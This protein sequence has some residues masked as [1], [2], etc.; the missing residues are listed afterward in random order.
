MCHIGVPEN[1]SNEKFDT[2]KSANV[3]KLPNLKYVK[4]KDVC[5]NFGS[6]IK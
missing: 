1:L 3:E 6:K 2:I 5:I 4:V